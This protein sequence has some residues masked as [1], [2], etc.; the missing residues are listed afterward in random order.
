MRQ[1]LAIEAGK[2][3]TFT[4][5]SDRSPV[6]S[7]ALALTVGA[8]MASFFGISGSAGAVGTAKIASGVA[9]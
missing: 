2:R 9:V 8:A 1:S 5:L 6:A 4:I 3:V 7:G